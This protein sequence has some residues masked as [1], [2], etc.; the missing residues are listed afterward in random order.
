MTEKRPNHAQGPM[1]CP[2]HRDDVDLFGEGAA[3]HWY[4]AYAIL[5]RDAPVLRLPGEGMTPGSDGFVLT[6]YEDVARVVRDPER[7]PTVLSLRL[8]R[9]LR[10]GASPEEALAKANLMEVSMSTLRP[11]HA[12]YRSHR[13]ELTDP[14]VGPGSERHRA[15][16]EATVDELI[17]DWIDGDQVEF[18][19]GFARPLPQR[20]MAAVLGFPREDVPRLEAWGDAQVLPFVH[21][22]GHRMIVTKA[23]LAEQRRAL[24]GFQQYVQDAVTAKRRDPADDMISFL[25]DAHYE[26]LDRKLSDIEIAGIVYAMILGGLETTQYAIAEQ[27]LLLC[28]HP[29]LWRAVKQ[30]RTKLRA[31]VEEGMRLRSPTHGLSTRFTS[32][33]E[34]FQDV[35][36]P[37]GSLLHLRFGAANVDPDAFDPHDR[38]DLERRGVTRHL[39]FSAG[40]RVCPGASLSRLEQSIAWDRLLDRLDGISLA[41]GNDFRHQPGIMYGILALELRF[42]R[43]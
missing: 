36:V 2:V 6:K 43:A 40:P 27:A 34:V 41:P 17:D 14:W 35:Q 30:D 11:T 28:E 18:V 10:S 3:E 23:Q 22:Q 29:E 20:V 33:D 39:A 15:M 16:I 13:Q 9:I 8:E 24:E 32:R 7:F 26:A 12:L 42:T 5:H 1:R 37:A 38:V 4:E 31:F 21:G 19:R 25:C